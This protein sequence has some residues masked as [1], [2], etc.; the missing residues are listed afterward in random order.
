[1]S[2]NAR[3]T[4]GIRNTFAAAIVAVIG[5]AGMSAC[6]ED[7][8]DDPARPASPVKSQDVTVRVSPHYTKVDPV[9]GHVERCHFAGNAKDVRSGGPACYT[10][11]TQ[12]LELLRAAG[13]IPARPTGNG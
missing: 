6:A 3:R 8:A 9:T 1:M 10:P 5:V 12:E 4:R 2:R 7:Q 11:N 13:E